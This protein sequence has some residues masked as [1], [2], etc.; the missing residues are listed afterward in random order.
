MTVQNDVADAF[1]TCNEQRIKIEELT[2]CINRAK[3]I[4]EGRCYPDHEKGNECLKMTMSSTCLYCEQNKSLG[5]VL[6]I[7]DGSEVK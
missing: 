5:K 3:E 4:I 1:K 2:N 7:L 6:S